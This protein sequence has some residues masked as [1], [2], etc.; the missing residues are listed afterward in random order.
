MKER[1]E[2]DR[3]ARAAVPENAVEVDRPGG[4]ASIRALVQLVLVVVGWIL[5]LWAWVSVMRFT[6][7]ETVAVTTILLAAFA[8]G[9][10][11]INLLWIRHNVNIYKR[12]GPRK[13]V[14]R[15]RYEFRRDFL[16]RRQAADWQSLQ[17]EALIVV[18][19]DDEQK[20]FASGGTLLRQGPAAE[21]LA[22]HP[23]P[24]VVPAPSEEKKEEN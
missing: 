14:P 7:P 19:F 15:V 2:K 10:E 11:V 16:G 24:S 8:V 9:I 22:S 5:F 21:K 3:N 17:G 12:K 18:S 20:T 23:R 13:S 6:A 4:A 1:L